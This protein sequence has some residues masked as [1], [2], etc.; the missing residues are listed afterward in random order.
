MQKEN[1]MQIF[2]NGYW[3]DAYPIEDKEMEEAKKKVIEDIKGNF[4][5][6]RYQFPHVLLEKK[7]CR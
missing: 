2:S 1:W 4:R 6:Y 7:R 3:I 5:I